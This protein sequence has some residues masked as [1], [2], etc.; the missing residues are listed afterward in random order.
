MAA[1]PGSNQMM[2]HDS[3]VART[4]IVTAAF[5]R[6]KY[7]EMA[8]DLAL[9]LRTV[10]SLPIAIITDSRLALVIERSYKKV[11]DQVIV[12]DS[13]ARPIG[14][15]AYVLAKAFAMKAS[16]FRISLFLDA[17]M[18][19]FSTPDRLL[20][21]IDDDV[22]RVSGSY[23]SAASCGDRTHHGMPIAQLIDEF[24]IDWYAYTSLAAI[25]FGKTGGDRLASLLLDSYSI[26]KER[27]SALGDAVNDEILIAMLGRVTGLTFPAV[28]N[29]TYQ[30]L[31]MSFR[32]TD[33]YMFVH[34][35]PM[36]YQEAFRILAGIIGRRKRN[37]LPASPMLYWLSEILAKRAEQYGK[38]QRQA[39]IAKKFT[40]WL[41]E[42]RRQPDL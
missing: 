26:W 14:R 4:G 13:S 41:Y 6:R 16:P 35:A 31:D 9:S 37:A 27:M 25:A 21:G 28:P 3:S 29:P 36:R 34:V 23:H 39:A 18:V 2:N 7:I 32:V 5:G 40:E 8:V 19:C 10:T 17:D 33:D 42:S 20:D 15:E 1:H 38:S 30:R 22:V 11:F 24:G 12:V